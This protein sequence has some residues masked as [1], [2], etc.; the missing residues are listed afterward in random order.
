MSN[1]TDLSSYSTWLEITVSLNISVK[2]ASELDDAV[3]TFNNLIHEGGFLSTP[4]TEIQNNPNQVYVTAEIR[5]MVQNKRNLNKAT[6]DLKLW[7]TE[8]INKQIE[9]FVSNLS[10]TRYAEHYL[11]NVTKYLKL[12]IKKNTPIINGLRCRTKL[13]HMHYIYQKYFSHIE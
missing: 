8:I 7:L 13:K 3:E 1:K 4:S 2:S 11:W 9:N 5:T 6:K 12:P 10:V